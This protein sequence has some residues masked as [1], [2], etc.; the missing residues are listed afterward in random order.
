MIYFECIRTRSFYRYYATTNTKQYIQYLHLSPANLYY[1]SRAFDSLIHSI[2]ISRLEMI[3][4]RGTGVNLDAKI[5]L[6]S[7]IANIYKSAI[8]HF[9][10]IRRNIKDLTRHFTTILISAL[11]YRLLPPTPYHIPNTL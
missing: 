10:K 4:L 2:I 1:R 9:F 5:F 3:G 11:S 8:Y 7:Y 6:N